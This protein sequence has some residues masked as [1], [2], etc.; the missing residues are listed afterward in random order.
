MN[1]YYMDGYLKKNLDTAKEVIKK[2]WDM[3]FVVDGAEGSGKSVLAMQAAAYCDPTLT[4]DRIVFDAEEFKEAI[5]KA[6][7]YE[8]VIFD[9]AFRGLTG[10]Q[11]MTRINQS[12]VKMIA[13]IRQKNLFVFVVMPTF[14]DLEKYVALWRSRALL[15]V[16]TGD[17]FERGR[18]AFFN[19]DRKKNLYVLGKKFYSYG[20]AKANFFGKFTNA[21]PIDEQEY[22]K[23]KSKAL[24]SE[25]DTPR[26]NERMIRNYVLEKFV[27]LTK[28]EKEYVTQTRVATLLG[29]SKQTVTYFIQNHPNMTETPT[30]ES[31]FY[32]PDNLNN[33]PTVDENDD[34]ETILA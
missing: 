6:K 32:V 11:T 17:K 9:E 26:I 29:V 5:K 1:K 33:L 10:K 3:L 30:N 19:Y 31:K 28:D 7:P 16:Y 23:K 12:L 21:Y 22:R 25:P 27:N 20:K 4:V 15:H 24:H 34:E 13:E 18:F 14:F 8:A 2:D